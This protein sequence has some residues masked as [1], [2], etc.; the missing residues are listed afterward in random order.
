MYE[1]SI[2]RMKAFILTETQMEDEE[3]TETELIEA[4]GM[5]FRRDPGMVI[6]RKGDDD[7]ESEPTKSAHVEEANSNAEKKA[8]VVEETETEENPSEG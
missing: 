8:E 5:G 2:E 1:Q 3:P 7:V 6:R 4:S